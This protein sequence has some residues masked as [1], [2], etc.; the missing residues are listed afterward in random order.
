MED[1]NNNQNTDQLNQNANQI[2]D[3]WEQSSYARSDEE[4][5]NL[6]RRAS[7]IHKQTTGHPLKYDEHGNLKTDTDEAQKCPALH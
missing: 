4:R 3:A 2:F 7:D 5:K 1:N 6:A